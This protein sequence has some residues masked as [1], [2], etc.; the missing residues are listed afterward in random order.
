MADQRDLPIGISR[1]I[2]RDVEIV[3]FNCATCHTG[4]VTL[5][6]QGDESALR[7]ARGTGDAV[8]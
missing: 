4:T 7:P 3:W 5:P 6:N 1:R 8:Q 2:Y